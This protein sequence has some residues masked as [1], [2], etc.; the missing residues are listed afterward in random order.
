MTAK[1]KRSLCKYA[2]LAPSDNFYQSET[3]ARVLGSVVHFLDVDSVDPLS[4]VHATSPTPHPSHTIGGTR[5]VCRT[6]SHHISLVNRDEKVRRVLTMF[7]LGQACMHSFWHLCSVLASIKENPTQ[8]ILGLSNT[9]QIQDVAT[10]K[11][12]VLSS[13][14][15]ILYPH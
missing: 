2:K 3:L 1:R 6:M 4:L 12:G 10:R 14:A 15:S 9:R 13:L 7:V 11:K 8:I 5:M